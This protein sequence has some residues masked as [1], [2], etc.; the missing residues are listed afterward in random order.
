MISFAP[1]NERSMARATSVA[2]FPNANASSVRL[3]DRVLPY[4]V[5]PNTAERGSEDNIV[6]MSSESLAVDG[7]DG[8]ERALEEDRWE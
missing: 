7:K 5:V 8:R 1:C 3:M 2:A 6:S 4:W